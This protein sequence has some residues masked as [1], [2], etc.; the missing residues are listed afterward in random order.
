MVLV[1]IYALFPKM[2]HHPSWEE[3]TVMPKKYEDV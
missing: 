2:V 1:Y 3:C